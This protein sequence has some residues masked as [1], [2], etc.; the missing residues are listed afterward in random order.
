MPQTHWNRNE[1]DSCSGI[2]LGR[3]RD[4]HIWSFPLYPGAR[5]DPPQQSTCFKQSRGTPQST[6]MCLLLSNR[7]SQ[8]WKQSCRNCVSVHIFSSS[9]DAPSGCAGGFEDRSHLQ[10]ECL[11]RAS[12]GFDDPP[13]SP[14]EPHTPP[15][16][17]TGPRPLH[18]LNAQKTFARFAR[19]PKMLGNHNTFFAFYGPSQVLLAS[20]NSTKIKHA[21]PSGFWCAFPTPLTAFFE[22][23]TPPLRKSTSPAR[24]GGG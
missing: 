12:S 1:W 7:A 6:P 23:S 9:S 8:K 3:E 14:Y 24:G 18:P 10:V 21:K 5:K 17:L 19:K 20:S 2:T 13:P 11:C 22:I 4:D 16:H 15:L